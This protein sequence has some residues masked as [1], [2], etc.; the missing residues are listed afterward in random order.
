MRAL[1]MFVDDTFRVNR[2]TLNLG[3]RF[4]PSRATSGAYRP[5]PQG[6]PIGGIPGLDKLFGWN[7]DLTAP[8]LHLED[9]GRR[10]N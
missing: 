10:Q 4:D 1:G 7:V 3:V 8:R 9:H 6:N 5:R 2:L